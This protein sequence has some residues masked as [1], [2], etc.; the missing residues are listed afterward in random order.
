MVNNI[1]MRLLSKIIL[2]LILLVG[3]LI[4]LAYLTGNDHLVRGVRFTYLMGRNS[5]EIDDRDFF[6]YATIAA[7]APQPWPPASPSW[8][9][10]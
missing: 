2:G 6:P 7:T 4:A 9:L 8:P 5:P 3:A 10:R 1:L